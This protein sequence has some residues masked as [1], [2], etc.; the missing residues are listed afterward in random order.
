MAFSLI[1]KMLNGDLP[2]GTESFLDTH[3]I[4]RGSTGSGRRGEISN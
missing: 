3:L 4:V 1:E 2:D